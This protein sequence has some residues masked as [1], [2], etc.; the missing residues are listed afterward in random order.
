MK[1]SCQRLSHRFYCRRNR[2]LIYTGA[3]SLCIK[4]YQKAR[5]LARPRA[6]PL[7]EFDQH[8]GGLPGGRMASEEG[9]DAAG[10]VRELEFDP[11]PCGRESCQ[12]NDRGEGGQ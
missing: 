5:K 8:R 7:L 10:G 11:G 12:V 4:L 3:A 1:P 9:V 6:T 2:P